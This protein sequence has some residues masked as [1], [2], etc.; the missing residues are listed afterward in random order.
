MRQRNLLTRS[1][2]LVWLGIPT[3]DETAENLLRDVFAFH[4]MA[5]SDFIGDRYLVTV[6]AH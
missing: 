3:W 4:P 5:I 1:D 2:G 6:H